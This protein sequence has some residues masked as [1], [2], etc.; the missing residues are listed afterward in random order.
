MT[1]WCRALAQ[2]TNCGIVGPVAH[3]TGRRIYSGLMAVFAFAGAAVALRQVWL[4]RHPNAFECG[5]SPEEKFLNA[6]PLA[7]WWSGMFEA[8]GDCARVTWEFMLLAI[9]DWSLIFFVILG[10]LAVYAFF[11][12]HDQRRR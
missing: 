1:P 10:S 6:L 9:P 12:K 8:N 4:V 7:K 11:A 5:I 3:V 2:Q